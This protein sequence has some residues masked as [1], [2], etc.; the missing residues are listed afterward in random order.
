M[1]ERVLLLAPSQGLGGGIERYTATVEAAF[2]ERGVPYRRLNLLGADRDHRLG[3]KV[4]FVREVRRAIRTSREPIRLV[5]AHVNLLP[6]VR[7][8]ARLPR[9][10]GATVI[11]HGHEIWSRRRMRGRRAMR[12]PDVRVVAA[13][14]FSAGALAGTGNAG[15]LNPGLS[16]TWY[17]TLVAA[18]DGAARA[19]GAELRVVTA[20]RLADWRNK[21]LDTLVDALRLVGDDRVRLTVCGTGPVPQDLQR[22]LAPHSGWRVLA[23]LPDTA[24][25]DELAGADL[26]VLAT[27]TRNGAGASGEGFGLVLLEAQIAG[28]PVVAP[29]YGGSGDAFVSGVTG[30]S[31]ADE[32]PEALAAV[33]RELLADGER[34]RRMGRAAASWSRACFEP[35]RYG[36]RVVR[37]LLGSGQDGA[38][39]DRASRDG[40]AHGGRPASAGGGS[41]MVDPAARATSGSIGPSR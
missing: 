16:A 21:G 9:F 35:G 30:L 23:D 2:Q 24:L 13:S 15:V 33:L 14:N 39:Q 4:A 36:D 18:G 7:M 40:A 28:T 1:T 6:V 19:T 37:A 10:R 38:G 17:S 12:R 31:P 20:F 25:A 26:F 32:G 5:L 27:R 29:A 8:V 41:S 3:T 34:R 11:V 22:R